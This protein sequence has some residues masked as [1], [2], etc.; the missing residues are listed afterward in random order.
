[1]MKSFAK[2]VWRRGVPAVLA[3]SAFG[4]WSAPS[5]AAAVRHGEPGG[6]QFTT[7]ARVELQALWGESIAARQERVAC[8]GGR[9]E[10]DTVYIN[11]VE[12][13]SASRADSANISANESL[14]RCSPPE[15]MGTVHTH[16]ARF[17][18]QPYVIF[19]SHDRT[20]MIQWEHE[21]KSA[22]VFCILYSESDANCEA[23]NDIAGQASYAVVRGNTIL[24]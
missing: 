13:L 16:I 11:H 14:Q 18:G 19:S 17:D 1:M 9:I 24:P 10:R 3:T 23:G 7:A 12:R 21:W 8:L 2:V 15:W 5:T 22:G 4:S 6:F 20:V